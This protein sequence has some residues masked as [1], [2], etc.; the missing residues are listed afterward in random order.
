[1][2]K[3]LETV[4]LLSITN[5]YLDALLINFPQSRATCSGPSDQTSHSG[6]LSIKITTA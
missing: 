6:D 5:K 2:F 3:V 1:M 4:D